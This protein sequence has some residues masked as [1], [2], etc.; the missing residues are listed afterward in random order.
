MH[1]PILT[2]NVS[3]ARC[4]LPWTFYTMAI[5]SRAFSIEDLAELVEHLLQV[6][7]MLPSMD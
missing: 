7:A 4:A 6:Q 5:E 1:M 2:C 3:N